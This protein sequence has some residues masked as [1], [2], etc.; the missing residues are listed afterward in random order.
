MGKFSTFGLSEC[1]LEKT[2]MGK[3]VRKSSHHLDFGKAVDR[4]VNVN[5]IWYNKDETYSPVDREKNNIKDKIHYFKSDSPHKAFEVGTPFDKN[6]DAP[7]WIVKKRTDAGIRSLDK[8]KSRPGLEI[9]L[10]TNLD[11]EKDRSLENKKRPIFEI[12]QTDRKLTFTR[13]VISPKKGV[14]R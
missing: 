3:I 5:K 2:I 14:Y 1:E 13:Q 10:G 8:V 6:Y 12:A 9:K 4:P 11:Y 7:V